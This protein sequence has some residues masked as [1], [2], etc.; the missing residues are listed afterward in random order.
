MAALPDVPR[1]RSLLPVFGGNLH[2]RELHGLD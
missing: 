1:D 2:G